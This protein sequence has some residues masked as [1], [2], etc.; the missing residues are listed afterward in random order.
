MLIWLMLTLFLLIMPLTA[1]FCGKWFLEKTPKKIN[2]F[3][4][5][6]TNRSMKSQ[7]S[8]D[9]AQQ[10]CGQIWKQLGVFSVPVSAALFL[11]ALWAKHT[12]QGIWC[13][14]IVLLQGAAFVATI[15]PVERALKRSFDQYGR[16][17]NK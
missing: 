11:P 13:L 6:R 15:F 5:Y 12:A 7:E 14:V 9:F 8:W 16:R 2:R 17:I 4:G 1:F 10:K 3:S